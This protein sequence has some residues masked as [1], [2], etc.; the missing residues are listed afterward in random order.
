MN[1]MP[2]L[3]NCPG[4]GKLFTDTGLGLCVD[5]YH[6]REELEKLVLEYVREHPKV[7]VSEIVED[8]GV[9]IRIVKDMLRRG[10]FINTGGDV[11]YPCSRCGQLITSGAYCAKCSAIL[12]AEIKSVSS[13]MLA[14][15]NASLGNA[16]KTS[17]G[18]SPKIHWTTNPNSL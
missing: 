13:K 11:S 7:T 6:K 3:R 5:C 8:T 1:A 15:R 12:H 4:C 17:G 18:R 2:K 9:D 14:R 10:M 16:I